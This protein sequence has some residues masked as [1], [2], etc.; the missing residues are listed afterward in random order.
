MTD[1]FRIALVDGH[2]DDDEEDAIEDLR[3]ELGLSH[4]VANAIRES[5]QKVKDKADLHHCPHCGGS[6]GDFSKDK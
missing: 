2:I 5:T 1:K 4:S 3:K 6:L